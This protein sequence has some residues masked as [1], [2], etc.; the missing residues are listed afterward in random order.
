MSE[1]NITKF[2]GITMVIMQIVELI[3]SI[4]QKEITRTCAENE[5]FIHW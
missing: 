1:N 3:H 4:T 2:D 5:I